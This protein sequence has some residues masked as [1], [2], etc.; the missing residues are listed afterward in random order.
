MNEE[1]IGLWSRQ[2]EHI[3]VYKWDRYYVVITQVM[4]ATV[5]RSMWW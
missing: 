3:R 2:T 1:K 4:E 5:E